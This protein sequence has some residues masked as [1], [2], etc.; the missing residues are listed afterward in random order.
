M[1]R[2][3]DEG[4]AARAAPPQI[5]RGGRRRE[6]GVGVGPGRLNIQKNEI[7]DENIRKI[8]KIEIEKI[9]KNG[10]WTSV[11]SANSKLKFWGNS[12][13]FDKSKRNLEI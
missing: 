12:E 4:R 2:G 3:T 8:K 11:N 9:Q 5:T 1:H 7:Q 13:K 10:D 6:K